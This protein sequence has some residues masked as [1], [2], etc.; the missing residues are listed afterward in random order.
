MSSKILF[1]KTD[2]FSNINP[3]VFKILE[4]NFPECEIDTVDAWKI[5]KKDTSAHHF[6]INIYFFIKEYGIEII[7]GHKKWKERG[8]WYFATSYISNLVSKKIRKLC[9]NKDYKFSFQ[10]QSLFNGKIKNIP[11]YIYTDHT[12][13]TNLYYPD[14]D[15]SQY[16]RSKSF[17]TKSEAKAYQEAT[18]IFTFGSLVA[19][20]LSVQYHIPKEKTLVVYA[21]SNVKYNTSAIPNPKKYLLKNILFVGVEWERKGGPILVEIFKKVLEKHPDASLTIVGCRPK[22]ISLPN[23]DILGK[24]PVEQIYPY[25]NSASVFCLPTLREPFGIV[26]V[27]AMNYRLPVISNNIGS[28][29]DL[30][31]NGYNGYLIN[32]NIN[33]YTNAICRLFDNPSLCMEMGENGYCYA[34]SKFRWEIVGQSIKKGIDESLPK[35][36]QESTCQ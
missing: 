20:S 19:R 33:E 11:N 7:S 26:L 36:K 25:Y 10:T 22:N 35:S 28:I 3:A 18:V 12:T 14:I 27:E 16:M 31:Q 5:I 30:I 17:I 9:K 13:Q 29:P 15:A 21:G 6:L 34:Q 1:I 8:Q 32:N 2:S 23:C 4:T 24:I